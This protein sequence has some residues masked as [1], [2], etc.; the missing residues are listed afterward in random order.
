MATITKIHGNSAIMYILSFVLIFN[1]VEILAP[2]GYGS[3]FAL[4]YQVDNW[5]IYVTYS[6]LFGL[7]FVVIYN[8]FGR[9]KIGVGIQENRLNNFWPLMLYVAIIVAIFGFFGN[10][11]NIALQNAGVGGIGAQIGTPGGL[12]LVAIGGAFE[13]FIGGTVLGGIL[14][15]FASIFNRRTGSI[16]VDPKTNTITHVGILLAAITGLFFSLVISFLSEPSFVPAG[17]N[18]TLPLEYG[19]FLGMLIWVLCALSYNILA[20][21]F[22]GI[23]VDTVR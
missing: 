9:I 13:G 11:A 18:Y 2:N 1:L 4:E 20:K 10:Y 15:I 6:L 3:F 22:G 21:A 7:L 17:Y 23:K 16:D 14:A 5:W 19:T 8:L 12:L